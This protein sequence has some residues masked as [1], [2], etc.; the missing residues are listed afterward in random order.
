MRV[1]PLAFP[2]G[3]DS[4]SA[5]LVEPRTGVPGV[6]FVHGWAGS[7]ERD[8][9][10]ARA[11]S[12]FGFISLTFD[13][14]GHG[15]SSNDI[16]EMTREDHLHDVCEAYDTLAKQP[17]VDPSSIAVVGSSYGGYLAGIALAQRPVRW[18]ALRVPALYRDDDWGLP[19]AQLD[20]E[21][22]AAYRRSLVTPDS[23]LALRHCSRF[24]GDVLIVESEYDEIVPHPTIASYLSSFVRAHSVTYRVISG[25]D[26]A[27]SSEA[28]RRAYDQLLSFWLREMIF[29][30]R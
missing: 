20:K 30:A 4:I 28:S 21:D 19:K 27:L 6:L 17:Q 9:A 10:R 11:L 25:A 5:R 24:T 12:Q 15:G 8:T 26:H 3:K 1:K 22:L 29:G 23:N 7:Q 2:V 16:Q 18:L 14:R 13:L